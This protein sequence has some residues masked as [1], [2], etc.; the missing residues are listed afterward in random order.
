M[1]PQIHCILVYL[2]LTWWKDCVFT[3]F[4]SDPTTMSMALSLL[5]FCSSIVASN[6]NYIIGPSATSFEDA[7]SYCKSHGTNLATIGSS[8]ALNTAQANCQNKD[9]KRRLKSSKSI[10]C[11]IGLWRDD[12]LSDWQWKDGSALDY[13]FN[14]DG[15]ATTNQSPWG[16]GEPHGGNWKDPQCI[17]LYSSKKYMW[18]EQ[19]CDHSAKYSY[20][21]C[22]S[23]HKTPPPTTVAPTP[24]PSVR[25]SQSPS[26]NPSLAPSSTP[27][28]KS[29]SRSP[30]DV[31]SISPSSFPSVAPTTDP[32]LNPT[33]SPSFNPSLA[34]T[35]NP[36]QNPSISPTNA[37]SIAP[38][39]A[40][41]SNPTHAPSLTPSFAPS[42]S[43]SRNPSL[44][45]SVAPSFTPSAAP[46]L[47]PSV[48]PSLAPSFAPSQPPT[49]SPSIN[50]TLAP[51][52]HPTNNPSL[53]PTAAPSSAPSLAPSSSPSQP[54]S[55]PV[56]APTECRR[57]VMFEFGSTI[58]DQWK[59]CTALDCG[60]SIQPQ[61]DTNCALVALDGSLKWITENP[62]E[63][64]RMGTTNGGEI[65]QITDALDTPYF[66]QVFSVTNNN[67]MDCVIRVS[68][69]S[70][71]ALQGDVTLESWSIPIISYYNTMDNEWFYVDQSNT[72]GIPT[73][74]DVIILSDDPDD[75][76]S[77][78]WSSLSFL[79]LDGIVWVSQASGL[80]NH[81][82]SQ[83]SE[84]AP[85]QYYDEPRHQPF[86]IDVESS[87]HSPLMVFCLCI[88]GLLVIG[89]CGFIGM[90]CV[91]VIAK[92]F[93][94]EHVKVD[95]SGESSEMNNLI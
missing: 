76:K 6:T 23:V 60:V 3:V 13:G 45:P 75:P 46:S 42:Q 87:I 79:T 48:S 19:K 43:P 16:S 31:P 37:P 18:S 7:Q 9:S 59:A 90:T 17:T 32:S 49:R 56:A 58:D 5:F 44:A 95:Y 89:L 71:E 2:L 20:P 11:W 54:S 62:P 51:T 64:H 50:P 61:Y 27:P 88:V 63:D 22:N 82:S 34:P 55:S 21:L 85:Y 83:E 67:G 24:S 69:A 40:P 86:V 93:V 1:L 15:S 80:G 10:G 8:S 78:D 72:N 35:R 57:N 29:P 73:G 38:T 81:F 30:T 92:R 4:L 39:L 70:D 47:A 66:D 84:P 28:T 77:M 65:A 36:T 94:V 26:T 14:H 68:K 53:S 91:G 12:G 33:K 52:R 74:D 25:P 41:S